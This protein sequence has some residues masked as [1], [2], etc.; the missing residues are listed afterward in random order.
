MIPVIGI[1][2]GGH[3]KVVIHI[4]RAASRY[5]IKGLTD[6]KE[7]LYGTKILGVPVLGGDDLLEDFFNQGIRHA[8]IGVGTAG[9]VTNRRRA[10]EVARRIGFRMI[11]AVHP[12]AVVESSAQIGEGPTI[13]A[14]AVVNP[15]SRLGA[16]V[17]VNTGAIVEHDCILADHVHVATRACL[18]GGVRVGEGAHIGAGAIILQGIR[19]GERSIV[20]AGA[21]VTRDVPDGVTVTGVPARPTE[22]PK[23]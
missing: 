3:S 8:F 14:N 21:V 17:I 11:R 4:I 12:S 15:D 23:G 16:N 19:I 7:S 1:G 18:A 22:A 6:V 20:G 9:N 5:E 10:F 2:A 13:M